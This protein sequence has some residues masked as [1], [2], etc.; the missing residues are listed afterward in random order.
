VGNSF[1]PS[2]TGAL[3]PEG[4]AA[5]N[6]AVSQLADHAA[7]LLIVAGFKFPSNNSGCGHAQGLCQVLTGAG[8]NG[9]GGNSATSTAASADTLI[10][11]A[12]NPMGLEPLALYAGL[13]LGYINERLSFSSAGKVRSAEG[14]PYQVY[15]DLMGMTGS[16]PVAS[17]NTDP[18]EMQAVVDELAVRRK[19][20]N[21]LVRE[22]IK[23][24]SAQSVMSQ[25]DKDRL[26]R[27][28]EGIRDIET[29][30][31]S[32]GM[33]IGCDASTLTEDEFKAVDRKERQNGMQEDISLLHMK[34]VAFA[35]ACNLNRTASMQIG[36]GT[37]ATVYDVPSNS[38]KW[39]FHFVSHRTQSDGSTGNDQTAAAAHAEIDALRMGTLKKGLDVFASYSSAT[40][41]LLD[42]AFVL[43][44]NH[45]SDGPSHSFSNLPV[46]I[47]GSGGGLLK[48]GEYIDVGGGGGGGGGFGGGGGGVTNDHLLNTLKTANGLPSDGT[49]AEMLAGS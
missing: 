48:Q 9:G 20:V 22:E 11:Q 6:R 43:W 12:V 16:S 46:V 26:A 28:L 40:G 31:A 37:D 7:R 32:Q 15:K 18:A 3:T 27:H 4:M 24:L 47:A 35:F 23:N 2:A 14:N 13:K 19:S 41:T 45:I 17:P 5:D 21:D 29:S 44:T 10:A 1:W 33:L 39:G 36:D 30:M 38:R 25:A 42:N 8:S 34:L 49:Q